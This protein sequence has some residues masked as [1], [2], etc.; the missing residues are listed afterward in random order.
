M[1]GEKGTQGLVGLSGAPGLKGQKGEPGVKGKASG[2][3]LLV[4]RSGPVVRGLGVCGTRGVEVYWLP[5]QVLCWDCP[6]PRAHGSERGTAWASRGA[7]MRT[8]ACVKPSCALATRAF[9][10]RDASLSP[11]LTCSLLLTDLA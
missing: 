2:C 6:Q 7:D 10:K 9:H 11:S 5:G 4:L 8:C 3:D 1:K